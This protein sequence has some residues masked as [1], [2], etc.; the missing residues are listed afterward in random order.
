MEQQKTTGTMQTTKI[1]NQPTVLSSLPFFPSHKYNHRDFHCILWLLV[2]SRHE[3]LSNRARGSYSYLSLFPH[4]TPRSLDPPQAVWFA[5]CDGLRRHTGHVLFVLH[6]WRMQSEWNWWKQGRMR[7]S[8][9]C[10][11]SDRQ[12]VHRLEGSSEGSATGLRRRNVNCELHESRLI[13]AACCCSS[14]TVPRCPALFC[15]APP[16]FRCPPP[17][18]RGAPPSF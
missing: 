14:E 10:S 9:P 17:L 5:S 1:A 4:H 2:V 3:V 18:F 16:L 8:S 11:Y 12:M 13:E 15:C 6:H 7:T